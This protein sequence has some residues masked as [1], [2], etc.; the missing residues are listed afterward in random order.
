MKQWIDLMRWHG[1]LPIAAVWLGLKLGDLSIWINDVGDRLV[2][3]G[4]SR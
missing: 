3:W 1:I 4:R 2:E